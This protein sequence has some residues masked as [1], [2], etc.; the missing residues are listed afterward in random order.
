V[1]EGRQATMTLRKDALLRQK[2]RAGEGG[3][4]ER[5]NFRKRK[6]SWGD[7]RRKSSCLRKNLIPFPSRKP[8]L[9]KGGA[10]GEGFW[11]SLGRLKGGNEDPREKRTQRP[12][13]EKRE[14][15]QE[16][17]SGEKIQKN[18]IENELIGLEGGQFTGKPSNASPVKRIARIH[19]MTRK[20]AK[21]EKQR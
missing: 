2:G 10:L 6:R 9:F 13:L 12:L 18:L 7:R 20:E 14:G 17:I 3:D 11:G 21:E 1:P 8:L 15:N 19:K 16:R 4:N 5:K